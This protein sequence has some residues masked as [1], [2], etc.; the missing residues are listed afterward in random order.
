MVGVPQYN[1]TQHTP[2]I[3][4]QHDEAG[5]TLRG[6][7]LKPK[8]DRFLIE[9]LGGSTQAITTHPEWFIKDTAFQKL[10]SS[11][12]T[13]RPTS[14]TEQVALNYKVRI[15]ALGKPN[16]TD[17]IN[18]SYFGNIGPEHHL[19]SVSHPAGVEVSIVS[20]SDELLRHIKNWI[21]PFFW[22]HNF[23]TRQ[24]KGFGSFSIRTYGDTTRGDEPQRF[25][26]TYYSRVIDLPVFELV[27]NSDAPS[28][29]KRNPLEQ[30][31]V[32]YAFMKSGFNVHNDDDYKGFA[33][34]WFDKRFDNDKDFVRAD[35]L[36]RGRRQ[37]GEARFVRALLGISDAVSWLSYRATIS[38]EH[39]PPR[40]QP[41]ISRI[42]SP[43]FFSVV[44][45]NRIFLLPRPIPQPVLGSTFQV[46]RDRGGSPR[47]IK[48]PT[49]DEFAFDDFLRIFAVKFN[50]KQ[51]PWPSHHG[52]GN[53]I[54]LISD[55]NE[56]AYF[57]TL[58]SL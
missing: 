32:T 2:M 48:V 17:N 36:N 10:R 12:T 29:L 58:R 53:P 56:A 42:P 22:L 1:L 21:R 49:A 8:L 9:R 35:I 14:Q 30:I 47:S 55:R 51:S 4:F 16:I 50:D 40:G 44:D 37:D 28:D 39:T 34:S 13:G 20:P 57:V 52:G 25:F 5:A 19:R 6:S 23:G 3:H 43:I 11:S 18:K 45:D 54:E 46:R 38:Y 41:I 24:S 7:E 33:L 26:Q 27:C 15:V 31:R